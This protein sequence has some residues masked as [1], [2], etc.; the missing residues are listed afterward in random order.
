MLVLEYG[1]PN[2]RPLRR[3]IVAGILLCAFTGVLVFRGWHRAPAASVAPVMPVVPM[4]G[5][6][7]RTYFAPPTTSA[8]AGMF[9]ILRTQD[10]DYPVFSCPSVQPTTREGIEPGAGA[11]SATWPGV[12]PG[13]NRF[14]TWKAGD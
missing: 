8:I 13:T 3:L 5:N 6:F 1:R 4:A 10:L 7:P 12:P 2:R 11:D 9:L 14:Q